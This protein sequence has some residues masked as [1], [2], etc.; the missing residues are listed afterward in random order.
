[1]ICSRP[2]SEHPYLCVHACAHVSSH[3]VRV[4]PS[5]HLCPCSSLPGITAL[6]TVQA[7]REVL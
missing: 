4:Y 5:E 3:G 1:M 2:C 7:G 6:S